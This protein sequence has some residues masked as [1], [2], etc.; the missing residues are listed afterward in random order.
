METV[1]CVA[2]KPSLAESV[3]KLLSNNHVTRGEG[4]FPVWQFTNDFNGKK[5]QFKFTSVIGH[6]MSIDFPPESQ[7]WDKDPLELFDSKV[8]K[9][10]ANPKAN[11]RQ[12]LRTAAKGAHRV[13][14]WLDNDREGENICFEVLDAIRPVLAKVSGKQIY[15]AIFSAITTQEVRHAMATLKDPNKDESDSVEARQ[16]L[17]LKIGVSFTRF[18]TRYFQAKFGDLDSRVISYG[19][20]QTPTLGFTVARHD[21]IVRF[22]PQTHYTCTIAIPSGYKAG[23]NSAFQLAVSNPS[24]RVLMRSTKGSSVTKTRVMAEVD[25]CKAVNHATVSSIKKASGKIGRPGALNTVGM[26]KLASTWLSMSSDYTMALAEQLYI[27]GAISYPRTESTRYP[28]SMDVTGLFRSFKTDPT[29]SRFVETYQGAIKVNTGGVNMGDHPPITPTG[30]HPGP[31]ISGDRARLYDMI[32]R[33]FLASNAP[34]AQTESVTMTLTVGESEFKARETKVT[35]PGFRDVL[36]GFSD[37]DEDDLPDEADRDVSGLPDVAAGETIPVVSVSTVQGVTRPPSYLTEAQLIDRMEKNGIGTDASIATHI[38]NIQERNYVTMTDRRLVP[39]AL[40]ICLVHGYQQI[41]RSLV[42]PQIRADIERDIM[43]VA[44]GKM[45]LQALLTKALADYRARFVNFQRHVGDMEGLFSAKFSP[46]TETGRPFTKCGN[47]SHYMRFIHQRPPRLYCP[48]CEETINVPSDGAVKML[49]GTF[50]PKDGYELI[51]V[52][53]GSNQKSYPICP[54]CHDSKTDPTPCHTCTHTTCP[55]ARAARLI[56][57][58]PDCAVSGSVGE[59]VLD[60]SNSGSGDWKA[61]CTRCNLVVDI[62]KK[63]KTLVLGDYCSKCGYRNITVTW[64]PHTQRTGGETASGC[65]V[66]SDSPLVGLSDV[67]H[68]RFTM[69]RGRGRGRGRRGRRGGGADAK[70]DWHPETP[71]AEFIEECRVRKIEEELN[72]AAVR[73]SGNRR[74]GRD[75]RRGPKDDAKLEDRGRRGPKPEQKKGDQKMTEKSEQK[76]PEKG[77]GKPAEK[78]Q[79]PRRGRQK[80]DS[81]QGDKTDARPAPS[82]KDK[83]RARDHKPGRGPEVD[84]VA[85]RPQSQGQRGRGRGRGGCGGGRGRGRGRGGHRGGRGH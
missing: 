66:C 27:S 14:L 56:G 7:S 47:C 71:L 49:T 72:K 74:D 22:K 38:K 28:D 13:I 21:E 46:L 37:E 2:E 55:M 32:C 79:K 48:T 65:L 82:D 30:H 62:L 68:G 78:A 33:V 50:C 45:T 11:V 29:F 76:K 6:V 16:E 10:E 61:Y 26:M 36:L 64:P 25:R 43:T 18:Q 40:G 57:P 24:Y 12:H 54:R 51:M 1:F 83:G 3:A 80:Q 8:V 52:S 39:T 23:D 67:R 4:K 42:S 58:C 9:V 73:D 69:A 35:K 15:R 81:K 20:C 34:N 75:D 60:R 53:L 63:A 17:D 85:D 70:A 19:P 84:H 31:E 77:E 5:C 59:L 44:E 41:D